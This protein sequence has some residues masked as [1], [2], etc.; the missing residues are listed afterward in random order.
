MEKHDD[1]N[2]GRQKE[3]ENAYCAKATHEN[4]KKFMNKNN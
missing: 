2:D 1:D 3:A 4:N